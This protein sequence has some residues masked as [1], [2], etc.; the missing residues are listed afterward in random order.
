MKIVL[1]PD[2][3]KGSL[4]G[5]EF[6][7]LVQKIILRYLPAAE[8]VALPLA[9]GGD[10]TAEV[11]EAKLGA[12]RLSLEVLDPLSRPIQTDYLWD[13]VRKLAFIEMAK[14]SG[15]AL[16]G[17]KERNPLYTTTYGT[18][19]MIKSAIDQGAERIILG[20][21]GSATNDAGIGLAAAL[22]YRFYDEK[23]KLLEPTGESLLQIR[24][25]GPPEE[26][27]C[28]N[29][30]IELACDVANPFYG[31]EGAAH[32]YGPQK[33]ADAHQVEL[34]DQG[35][36]N[37]ARI[38]KKHFA[39]DLQQIPGS[40]AAGGLGG[41]AIAFLGAEQRSGIELVKD[42]LD[43]DSQIEG[44][45]WIITGEGALDEQSLYGKTIKGICDSAK[46]RNIPVAVFCGHLDLSE[47]KRKETGI[48]YATSINQPGQP[49]K[50]AIANT[51]TNLEEAVEHFV[52]ELILPQ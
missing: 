32:V 34:L 4:R 38:L 35:L 11:L 51:R 6:C 29:R 52:K 31:P 37:I 10:G 12:K 24:T 18:G 8:I 2:K 36:R 26:R 43:F 13:P 33:G 49:L 41:G 20:L 15:Y 40:G 42:L 7:V 21:G 9:D 44:A 25:I 16:L 48:L 5:P 47:E 45:D 19:Q 14:A 22:G 23:G 39:L 50:E 30:Q 27:L 1:A 46:P 28:E 17:E 3:F